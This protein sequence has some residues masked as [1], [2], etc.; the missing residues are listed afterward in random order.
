MSDTSYRVTLTLAH[1]FEYV[2]Q[3]DSV[4]GA[5][6]AILDEPKPLG[7]GVGPN[8]TSLLAAAIGNCLA[9][10]LQ[11]CLRKSHAHVEHLQAHVTAHVT[12]NEAGR[13]RISGIDVRLNPDV[14]QE[15]VNRLKRC[16]DLF[17]DFCIVTESVR[18]GIPVTV[19][20]RPVGQVG[21]VGQAG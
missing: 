4:P 20:V 8:A 15:D 16:E 2:A 12:R 10:S 13:F 1:D 19:E 14:S 21:L 18:H 3:F 11:F 17:E 9:A 6:P 7:S 5:A